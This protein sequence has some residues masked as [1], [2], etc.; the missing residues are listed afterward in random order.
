[1]KKRLIWI[2]WPSFLMAGVLEFVVFAFVD[3]QD[4]HWLHSTTEISRQT[5]YTAAFFIFWTATAL[6]GALTTQLSMSP[7]E[8]N[9]CPMPDCERPETCKVRSGNC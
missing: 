7:F 3:P 5:A 2:V 8:V 6:S 1:M 9:R 4:L